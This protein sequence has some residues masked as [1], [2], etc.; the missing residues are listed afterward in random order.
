MLIAPVPEPVELT[1]NVAVVVCTKLPLVPAIV[2]VVLPV[3]VL[4]LVCTVSVELP[5]PVTDGG[6]NVA[7]APVGNPVMLRFTEPL[8][9]FS[10][11]TFT[12]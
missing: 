8:K 4:L 5:E 11:P 7:V 10:A 3:G 6:V 1:V 12:A 2:S 9:P